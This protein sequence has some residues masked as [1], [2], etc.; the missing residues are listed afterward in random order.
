MGGRQIIWTPETKTNS[1]WSEPRRRLQT[2]S[3]WR[4]NRFPEGEEVAVE[5][6]VIPTQTKR[7][8]ERERIDYRTERAITVDSSR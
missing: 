4:T 6:E 3:L 5:M 7:P 8:R 1:V 2:H